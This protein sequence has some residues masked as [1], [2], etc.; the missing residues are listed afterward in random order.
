MLNQ[1]TY[2]IIGVAK[3]VYKYLGSSLLE[4]V[5]QSYMA[6]EFRL[7]EIPT[8]SQIS[9]S[10][11]YKGLMIDALLKY[12]FYVDDLIVIELKSVNII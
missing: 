11:D 10:I 7:I 8:K 3:E 12:D 4:S 2:E 6:E 5:Y 1:F 9:I